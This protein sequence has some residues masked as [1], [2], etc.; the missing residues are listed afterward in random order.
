V[1]GVTGV[2]P[3]DPVVPE[4]EVPVPVPVVVP[5]PMPVPGVVGAAIVT[6]FVC[7]ALE[8]PVAEVATTEN[9]YGAAARPLIVQVRAVVVVQVI[10][11]RVPCAETT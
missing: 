8:L 2:V 4:P 6:V 9:V 10:G 7:A 5:V 11:L 1:T 3:P